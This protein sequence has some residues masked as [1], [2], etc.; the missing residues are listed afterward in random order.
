MKECTVAGIQMAVQPMDI[1]ANI[2]KCCER[3]R[4]AVA[5]TGADLVVFPETVT[6][7]FTP[8]VA[9]ETFYHMLGPIPG[10]HTERIQA[11]AKELGVYVVWPLYEQ[12]PE[13]PVIYN[14]AAVIDRQGEVAAVYRKTHLFP[15]ERL[16]GG[17]WATPGDQVV[18]VE[19]D[20]AKVGVLICYD[21]DFP[22]L[23]RVMALQG[24]EV[25]V[26]PAAFLRSA[27]I[28][29]LTTMAR[30]YDNHVYMVA[31][32]TVG[33][34]AGDNYYFGNSMIVDPIAWKLAQARGTEE[35]VFAKLSADPLRH[36]TRGTSAP[37]I[38]D[39]VEDRNVSVYGGLLKEGKG[40]FEPARRIPYRK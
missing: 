39:H 13:F 26:R 27:N 33:R 19:T 14:A 35:T 5:E 4:Q 1:Q 25:I 32:N 18:V 34:D 3:L 2:D 16:A 8:D 20:F 15:T 38:F 36:I 17:G 6:T 23:A 22:E 10:P 31:V 11:L 24:A 30:A 12:G 40:P 7:G 37:M 29:E 28:W 21:G 9:V